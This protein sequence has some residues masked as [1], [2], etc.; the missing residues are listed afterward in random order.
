MKTKGKGDWEIP[1]K[2]VRERL[3]RQ[4]LKAIYKDKR[5]HRTSDERPRLK[6]DRSLFNYDY[7]I[8]DYDNSISYIE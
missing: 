7:G 4:A 6:Q 2:T 8:Y 3:R 1:A 5:R